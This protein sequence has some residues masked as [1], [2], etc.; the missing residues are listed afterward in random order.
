MRPPAQ[1]TLTFHVPSV[2]TI[3]AGDG[4]LGVVLPPTVVPADLRWI[5][6]VS[7]R[8]AGLFAADCATFTR[9]MAGA[10]ATTEVPLGALL[11]VPP[12]GAGSPVFQ[13]AMVFAAGSDDPPRRG[14]PSDRWRAAPP[15]HRPGVR[16]RHV[17]HDGRLD[18]D[19]RGWIVERAVKRLSRSEPTYL[20]VEVRELPVDGETAIVELMQSVACVAALF[21]AVT[22]LAIALPLPRAIAEGTA[23][24]SAETRATVEQWAAQALRLIAGLPLGVHYLFGLEEVQRLEPPIVCV[25]LRAYRDAV[26]MLDTSIRR[27]AAKLPRLLQAIGMETLGMDVAHRV[28]NMLLLGTALCLHLDRYVAARDDTVRVHARTALTRLI[29]PRNLAMLWDR[30]TEQVV[31]RAHARRIR[32]LMDA[33][34]PA[35]ILVPSG[36]RT[37]QALLLD[38]GQALL[39]LCK[40]AVG[41]ARS[42]VHLRQFR[43]SNGDLLIEVINDLARAIDPAELDGLGT[44]GVGVEGFLRPDSTQMGLYTVGNLA[45]QVGLLGP[46]FRIEEGTVGPRFVAAVIIPADR[47]AD[48]V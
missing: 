48:S 27:N 17:R 4:P 13:G 26:E 42:K 14:G 39:E 33:P 43:L 1:A 36:D 9:A 45:R 25:A 38:L 46:L 41:Y 47:L 18:A 11:P 21:G 37:A 12:R 34:P 44:P 16:V 40:N 35:L 20:R 24:D 29:P 7:L 28:N 30:L 31:L 3:T 8:P 10:V 2:R 6:P 32:F 5:L 23:G 15:R 19:S 22:P